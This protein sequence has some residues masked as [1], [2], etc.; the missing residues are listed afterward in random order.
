MI[1]SFQLVGFPAAEPKGAGLPS[2]RLS[3]AEWRCE[4]SVCRR[5]PILAAKEEVP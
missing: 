4:H 2:G 1:G 5:E 3:L